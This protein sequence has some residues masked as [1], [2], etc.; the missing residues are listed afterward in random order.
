[1]HAITASTT[2]HTRWL[3]GGLGSLFPFLVHAAL[4][5]G[6]YKVRPLAHLVGLDSPGYFSAWGWVCGGGPGDE[7]CGEGTEAAGATLGGPS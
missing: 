6:T 1:M 2:S 4:A 7:R 3:C 5:A